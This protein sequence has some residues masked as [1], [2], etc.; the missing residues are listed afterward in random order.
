MNIHNTC[1]NTDAET[2]LVD[3]YDRL[4][5]TLP[6]D[7]KVLAARKDAIAALKEFG[8]PTRR[9]EAW[10]YTDLRTLMREA[11]EPAVKPSKAAALKALN[12]YE[13]LSGIIRLPIVNGHY[14]P[15]FAKEV[16]DAVIVSSLCEGES[17]F[18][19][20]SLDA[21]NT[22]NILN[23]AFATDGLSMIVDEGETVEETIGIANVFTG[24]KS[25]MA[26]ARNNIVVCDGATCA[27]SERHVGPSGLAYTATRVTNL[28]LGVGAKAR[29]VIV[30]EEGDMA[31]HLSQLNVT[32]GEDSEL[33]IYMLNTSG[34]LVRSEINVVV[35][36]ENSS[37]NI[38]GI[39]L[40]GNDNHVDVTTVLKHNVPNTTSSQVFRNVATDRGNGVFQGQ[41]QVAQ[42]AQKTDAA[43]AC[44]TLLLSD[45]CGFSTKPELEIFADDVLCAHGATIADLE[46]SH[47]FYLQTRGIPENEAR[48]LLIK[49]FLEEVLDDMDDEK[50]ADALVYRIDSWLDAR[51]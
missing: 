9:V 36:G 38:R 16:P 28:W 20:G 12:S 1:M 34:K 50:F 39:N 7:Y 13:W 21:D 4:G 22:I 17:A 10:H 19:D 30:Q 25:A 37:L 5:S 11:Y 48:N 49:A 31:T 42:I 35:S 26:S 15:E 6:G 27:F 46:E 3:I 14:F 23:T 8:L 44:N 43:M 41:I 33:E 2:K 45:E 29:W 40:V 24:D 18:I 32:L 47:L 51:N